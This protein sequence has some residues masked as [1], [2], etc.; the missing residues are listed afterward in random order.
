[1]ARLKSL[2]PQDVRKTFTVTGRV[3]E[4][5]AAKR[6]AAEMNLHTTWDLIRKLISESRNPKVIKLRPDFDKPR[7][8]AW[9]S[10]A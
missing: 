10:A 1:M 3:R 2:N 6:L 7:L 5:K 9:R 4:W 8:R